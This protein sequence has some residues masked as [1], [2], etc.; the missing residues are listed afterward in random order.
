MWVDARPRTDPMHIYPVVRTLDRV[1][2]HV[3]SAA[4][5]EGLDGATLWAGSRELRFT[6]APSGVGIA[7]QIC[8]M[9]GAP[10]HGN[11]DV[12]DLLAIAAGID[13]TDARQYLVPTLDADRQTPSRAC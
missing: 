12:N 3:V 2:D 6:E 13:R 5:F 1:I 7:A 11:A 8:R 10:I 4:M 9:A